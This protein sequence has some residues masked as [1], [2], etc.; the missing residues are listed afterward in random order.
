MGRIGCCVRCEVRSNR[1]GHA[2]A[3]TSD[4]RVK[5]FDMEFETVNLPT[6]TDG[7]SGSAVLV[8]VT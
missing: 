6:F 5:R 2:L 3:Q 1:L 8:G 4:L 7:A